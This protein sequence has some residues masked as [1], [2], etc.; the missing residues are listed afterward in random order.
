MFVFVKVVVYR[1]VT[2]S[3]VEERIVERA[4][5]K[6]KLDS[7]VIQKGRLSQ[8]GPQQQQQGPQASE[9]QEILQF[10]AQEVYRTQEE[11]SITDADI[12]IILADAEQRTAE[13]EAQL[14]RYSFA[15]PHIYTPQKETPL[16]GDTFIRR[17]LYRET[18][19]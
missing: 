6:L 18:P 8:R 17:H 13:I 4:A 15:T 16:K 11:S 7:L 2:G 1:F 9:L 10:G 3:T 14:Q 12:D 5:K 19:S